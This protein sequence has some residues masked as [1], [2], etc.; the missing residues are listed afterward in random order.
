MNK[1]TLYIGLN[2]MATKRQEISTV[3]AYKVVQNIVMSMADGCTIF[4][5]DGVYKHDDGTVVIEKSLKVELYGLYESVVFSIVAMLKQALR[6]ESIILQEET[7][8]SRFV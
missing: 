3:E 4:E 6:Q 2:D 8:N 5:A 7:V 1:T